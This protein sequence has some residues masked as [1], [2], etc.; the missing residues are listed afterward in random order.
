MIGGNNM[1]K[2]NLILLLIL[3]LLLVNGCK[4]RETVNES[5][6][7]NLYDDTPANTQEITEQSFPN[8]PTLKTLFY[9]DLFAYTVEKDAIKII[10]TDTIWK[11]TAIQIVIPE[12]IEGVPVTVIGNSAFYQ[13]KDTKS[14]V[15]PQNLSKIESC[16][17]YRCYELQSISIP[18]NV[19]FVDY[20]AF[21]HCSSLSSIS[22][23]S[24]NPNYSDINGVLFNKDKTILHTYPEGKTDKKYTI[25]SSVTE[26]GDSAFGYHCAHLQE[27]VIGK[28]VTTFPDYNIF[29]FPEDILLW[30]DPDSTAEQYAIEHHLNYQRTQG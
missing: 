23:D 27:I 20:E 10:E 26:I 30:V 24:E 8:E 14:F 9:N 22:V 3:I 19:C 15:L 2:Y 5:I 28:N 11:P 29:V 18:K 17:F 25:P 6:S 12:E 7:H 13:Y 1:K 16:A 21:F 4:K